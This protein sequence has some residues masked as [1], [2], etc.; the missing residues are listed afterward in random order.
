MINLFRHELRMNRHNLAVMAVVIFGFAFLMAFMVPSM[1]ESMAAMVKA[2]PSF[3]RGF[4]S[5]RLGAR[6]TSGFLGMG[7]THPVWFTMLGIWGIGYGAR[8]IASAIEQGTLGLTLA[9]PISRR[10]IISAKLAALFTGLAILVGSSVLGTWTGLAVHGERLPAGMSGLGWLAAGALSFY[11]LLGAFSLAVS[12]ASRE[13]GRAL[14]VSM[15]FAVGSFFLDAI[16]QVWETAKPFRP[17]SVFR[18]FEP[19]VLLDGKPLSLLAFGVFGIG[20]LA[21]LVFAYWIFEHR[22]LSV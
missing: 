13:S 8:G 4:V 12:A 14:G 2:I 6:T 1:R 9:Y 3:M 21:C 7:Y 11:C 19:S 5:Q 20:T 22:D 17:L 16:A 18:Y 10:A 15:G